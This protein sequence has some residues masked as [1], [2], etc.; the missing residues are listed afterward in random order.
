MWPKSMQFI[1]ASTAKKY[2]QKIMKIGEILKQMYFRRKPSHNAISS[3][4][5]KPVSLSVTPRRT[6]LV[7]NR[8]FPELLKLNNFSN[9]NLKMC[10]LI[11]ELS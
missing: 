7:S 2:W 6:H 3:E 11:S 1:V 9:T 5:A 8:V 4:P 10:I